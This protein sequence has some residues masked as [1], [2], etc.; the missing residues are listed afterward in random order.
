MLSQY[1]RYLLSFMHQCI[2]SKVVLIFWASRAIV[3]EADLVG[4]LVVEDLH[5]YLHLNREADD[6]LEFLLLP[7]RMYR[8]LIW[9]LQVLS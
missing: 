6:K 8:L 5:N 2:L 3:Q 7:H 4:D 1:S 9:L